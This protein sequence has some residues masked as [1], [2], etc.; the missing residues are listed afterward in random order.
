[1]GRNRVY[2]GCL[3]VAHSATPSSL[4]IPSSIVEGVQ[5]VS[6]SSE[7]DL[8]Q[9]LYYGDTQPQFY[10]GLSSVSF[11][12]TE[13]LKEFED[14]ADIDGANDY[15]NLFM[16]L[17]D[18]TSECLDP[19]NYIMAKYL[20]LD[21]L[22]YDLN[23]DGFFTLE[24]SYSGFSNYICSTSSAIGIP[25]C[26]SSTSYKPMRR[27][28]F[29]ISASSIPGTNLNNIALTSLQIEQSIRRESIKEPGIRTPYGFSTQYPV[30]T[31]VSIT[32]PTKNLY[33][34]MNWGNDTFSIESCESI[35]S[36]V[37]DIELTICSPVG[38]TNSTLSITDC[39]VKSINYAGG[40]TSGG[41]QN[42]SVSLTS[43]YDPGIEP[44]IEFPSDATTGCL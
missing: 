13:I 30:E 28:N 7:K 40:D 6:F 24:K 22:T 27:Q 8:Q 38:G 9:Y 3:G 26:S 20:L 29:D 34:G 21:S 10:T 15:T 2:Y 18:D 42:I 16:F 36:S 41:N 32:I 23:I 14:I 35:S 5:S 1:M 19:E 25:G 4:S 11:S 12:Y 37:G 33:G 17:G 31:Q 43:S 39:R 44:L